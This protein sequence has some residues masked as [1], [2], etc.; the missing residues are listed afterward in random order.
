MKS[1]RH[2][3]RTVRLPVSRLAVTLQAPTGAEDLLLLESRMPERALAHLLARRLS[4]TVDGGPVDVEALCMTDF[5]MLLLLLRQEV[6]GDV[7]RAEI[8]CGECGARADISL[9]ISEYLGSQTPRTPRGVEITDQGWFQFADGAAR[10][11]LPTGTDLLNVG[12]QR[13]PDR[14]LA[15]VCTGLPVVPAAVRRRIETAIEMLAPLLSRELAAE[16]PDCGLAVQVYF[17]VQSFVLGELC[18]RAV[19]IYEEVHLLAR[20]YGWPEE[21]ILALPQNRRLQYVELLRN[22]EMTA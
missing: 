19:T 10:F 12:R 6:A 1:P 3:T 15:K 18:A 11:R 21:L 4:H 22:Q 7:I 20:N 14:E 5:E 2:S 8:T 16:C 17:D 9:R 13:N